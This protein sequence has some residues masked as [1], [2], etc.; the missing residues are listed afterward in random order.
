MVNLTKAPG[1]EAVALH[2]REP[3]QYVEKSIDDLL[4]ACN[5]AQLSNHEAQRDLVE[6]RG[7]GEGSTML[8]PISLQYE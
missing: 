1:V 6:G 7:K 8:S 5:P 3:L 4:R 2:P